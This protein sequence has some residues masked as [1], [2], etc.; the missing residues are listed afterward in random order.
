MKDKDLLTTVIGAV[1]AVATAA[2]P[3]VN[4]SQGT[5][6]QGDWIQLA[7]AA[8]FGLLGFFTNKK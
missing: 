2:Q 3:I 8:I 1:G 5:F 4:A 6:H 7:M